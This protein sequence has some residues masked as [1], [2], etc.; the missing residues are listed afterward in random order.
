MKTL[1][2]LYSDIKTFFI[3][4]CN[5]E[6]RKML[7]SNKTKN[8]RLENCKNCEHQVSQFSFKRCGI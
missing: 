4:L 1:T 2:Y 6:N 5:K 3:F 7:V 8:E